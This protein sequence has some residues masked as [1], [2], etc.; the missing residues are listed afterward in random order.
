MSENTTNSARVEGG[1]V[2]VVHAE[3]VQAHLFE[4]QLDGNHRGGLFLDDFPAPG[5]LLLARI[6][7]FEQRVIVTIE[8]RVGDDALLQLDD[9]PDALAVRAVLHH[10]RSAVAPALTAGSRTRRIFGMEISGVVTRQVDVTRRSCT[11]ASSAGLSWGSEEGWNKP[12]P[13]ESV[14]T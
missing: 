13:W 3:V 11:F 7:L 2:D 8:D 12:V 5:V 10:L 14:G 9:R 4:A 1:E 6:H